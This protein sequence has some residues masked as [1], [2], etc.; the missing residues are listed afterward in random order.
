M[1]DLRTASIARPPA[2]FAIVPDG[3]VRVSILVHLPQLLWELGQDPAPVLAGAGVDPL[4]LADAENT[5]EFRTGGRLI[6]HCVASTGCGHFGLLLGQKSGLSDLGVVGLL[7]QHSADVGRAVESLA[8]YLYLHD[9]GG[10]PTLDVT[11]GVAML[12]YAVYEGATPAADQIQVA[13]T[14]IVN[15]IMRELCG[16]GWRAHEVLLSIR[17][18]P[19]PEP[20]RRAFDAPL[21]FDADRCAVVFPA[22]LLREPVAAAAPPLRRA[23]DASVAELHRNSRMGIVEATRRAL[24]GLLLGGRASEDVVAKSFSMNRRTLNRRLQSEGTSFR[25]LLEEVRLEAARRMLRDSEAPVHRIA[26]SLGYSGASAFGRAFRR[27]SGLSP[28]E[29]REAW[30]EPRQADRT[31]PSSD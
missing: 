21:V 24:C 7:V 19:D 3:H 9:R 30:P 5:I 4:L 10:V 18:P 13:S 23:L 6:E 26:C 25:R 17:R 15:N 2:G 8:S 11:E 20:F 29:W 31:R 14:V 1:S 22:A 28:H 12:G 27:W 16:P